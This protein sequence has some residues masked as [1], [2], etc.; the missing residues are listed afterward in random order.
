[1]TTQFI[2]KVP[3][4]VG[5][6]KIVFE[7][8]PGAY[9]PYVEDKAALPSHAPFSTTSSAFC[10]AVASIDCVRRAAVVS[11]TLSLT[12]FRMLLAGRLKEPAEVFDIPPPG[13]YNLPSS[14]NSVRRMVP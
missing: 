9:D 10:I 14:F 3:R 13:T 7:V 1:M 8:G 6:E 5:K 11:L 12:P 2:S 4:D